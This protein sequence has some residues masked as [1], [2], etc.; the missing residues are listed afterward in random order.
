MIAPDERRPTPGTSQVHGADA[1]LEPK[2]VRPRKPR[3]L[4][5]TEQARMVGMTTSS[6]LADGNVRFTTRKLQDGCVVCRAPSGVTEEVDAALPQLEL[7]WDH[8]EDF[9]KDW[10]LL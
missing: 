7:C 3:P 2:P 10:L 9:Q 4:V 8:W 5:R 6:D 1:G